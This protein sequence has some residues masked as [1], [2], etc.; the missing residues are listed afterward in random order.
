MHKHKGR[1]LDVFL[2]VFVGLGMATLALAWIDV[3]FPGVL[4]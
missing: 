1:A 4:R 2:A 3:L